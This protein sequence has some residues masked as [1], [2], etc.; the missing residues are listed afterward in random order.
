MDAALALFL[1]KGYSATRLED[2]AA[3]A[4]VTKGTLFI[5]FENKEDLFKS[6]IRES[7]AQ[8]DSFKQASQPS[9]RVSA[10]DTLLFLT[11]NWCKFLANSDFGK[12]PKLILTE[13]ANFPEITTLYM[14]KVIFPGRAMIAD[15]IRQGIES[16]EFKPIDPEMAA[17][18]FLGPL[19]LLL[20]WR[21]SMAPFEQT[22][23][24]ELEYINTHV[25]IAMRG[26]LA[27]P[28]N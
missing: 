9:I 1:E 18:V 20:V 4:N 8:L 12:L 3:K 15:V 16:G 14:E 19:F 10:Q 6:I 28:S 24:D 21:Y 23:Q 26:L 2:I 25:S 11:N 27:H 22:P 5:Y 7:L 17:R 13:A